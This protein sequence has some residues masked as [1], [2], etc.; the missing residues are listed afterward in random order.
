MPRAMLQMG[1]GEAGGE[2]AGRRRQD[3]A[4]QVQEA[5]HCS[6][7]AWHGVVEAPSRKKRAQP[8]RKAEQRTLFRWYADLR[9]RG[10]SFCG[11]QGFLAE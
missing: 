5:A 2:D 7:Q 1:G 8:Q 6:R 11:S 9:T 4:E 10:S 3:W